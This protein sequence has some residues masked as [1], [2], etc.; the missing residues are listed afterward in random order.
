MSKYVLE[1]DTEAKIAKL[2]KDGVE[3]PFDSINVYAFVD[4]LNRKSFEFRKTLHQQNPDKSTTYTETVADHFARA[5]IL[6][7]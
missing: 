2:T 1:Y 4:Y 3:E 5:C 7:D 6:G